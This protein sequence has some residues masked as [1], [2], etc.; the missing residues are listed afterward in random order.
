MQV[1]LSSKPLPVAVRRS[2]TCQAAAAATPLGRREALAASALLAA[3]SAA[4]RAFAAVEVGSD[5]PAFML[6]ATTGKDIS[7]G[8][9]TAGGRYAVVYFYNADFTSGCSLEAQRFQQ[10]LPAFAAANA[11]V[12]GIS[13]DLLSKHT[14]FCSQKSLTFPLLSD[15]DGSVSKLYGAD[16][17]LGP[18]GKFSDRQTFLISPQGQVIAKWK[19]ADGSMASVKTPEHTAQI[20]A[21]L[22]KAQSA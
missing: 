1:L 2:T 8:E 7:L 17:N 12:V 5:A 11:S 6:P 22:Q 14:E 18:F 21:A 16:L 4:P 20:L 9:L 13:M 19:E 3:L 10:A 15:Q